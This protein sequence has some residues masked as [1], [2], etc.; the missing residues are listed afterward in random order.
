MADQV[1]TP[2]QATT[3]I[4]TPTRRTPS[5]VWREIEDGYINPPPLSPRRQ[6][7]QEQIPGPDTPGFPGTTN[8]HQLSPKERHFQSPD[9]PANSPPRTPPKQYPQRSPSSIWRH[10]RSGYG[11]DHNSNAS[12]SPPEDI[13]DITPKGNSEGS[14]SSSN[15]EPSLVPDTHDSHPQSTC[16]VQ[17]KYYQSVFREHFDGFPPAQAKKPPRRGLITGG[18]AGGRRDVYYD[19]TL[20]EWRAI[21]P[22]HVDTD[23][24]SDKNSEKAEEEEGAGGVG[25]KRKKT[26]NKLKKAVNCVVGALIKGKEDKD[27]EPDKS[28]R[29]DRPIEE[30]IFGFESIY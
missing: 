13:D 14:A 3:P 8:H 12:S 17:P 24:E 2:P 15:Q 28:D 4:A 10:I 25:G 26:E 1:P 21:P 20:G 22:I 23:S 9:A 11:P 5:D 19:G 16:P 29:L 30:P 6:R 27:D 7:L 18:G